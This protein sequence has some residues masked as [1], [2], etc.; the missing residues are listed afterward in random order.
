MWYSEAPEWVG[1]AITQVLSPKQI[2][3]NNWIR[4]H[5]HALSPVHL[6]ISEQERLIEIATSG[7]VKILF[8]Q[9][10]LSAFWIGLRS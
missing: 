9:K 7:S 6:T 8:N 2:T 1:G 10:P 5:F 3:Q 4:Y